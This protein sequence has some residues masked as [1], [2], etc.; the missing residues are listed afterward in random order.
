[1]DKACPVFL[2]NTAKGQAMTSC[3]YPKGQHVRSYVRFRLGK[4]E[5]VCEHCRAQWGYGSYH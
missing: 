2:D 4:W 3:A 5:N 1:M